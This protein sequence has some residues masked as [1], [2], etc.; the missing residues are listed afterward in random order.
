MVILISQVPTCRR[1]ADGASAQP[2]PHHHDG[3]SDDARRTQYLEAE[4]ARVHAEKEEA[5]RHAYEQQRRAEAASAAMIKESLA[6][7][8][9]IKRQEVA[10]AAAAAGV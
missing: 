5:Q 7:Q 8:I 4:L 9:A 1:H 2:Q 3:G 6:K 10:E